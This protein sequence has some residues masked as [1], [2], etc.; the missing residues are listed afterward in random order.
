MKIVA[1]CVI[2]SGLICSVETKLIISYESCIMN[3]PFRLPPLI[4][5][6]KAAYYLIFPFHVL[7]Q[8][9]ISD[10]FIIWSIGRFK[11]PFSV[12]AVAG[13]ATNELHQRPRDSCGCQKVRK[14]YF[15]CVCHL[16]SCFQKPL[17]VPM[18]PQEMWVFHRTNPDKI[19]L[20]QTVWYLAMF[21]VSIAAF[22]CSTR[23]VLTWTGFKENQCSHV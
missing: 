2:S 6:N 21:S 7:L 1:D 23:Y 13:V 16:V 11:K 9:I 18:G 22:N 15:F 5:I 14:S 8:A 4:F 12:H 20:C 17:M 3:A 10:G 19:T